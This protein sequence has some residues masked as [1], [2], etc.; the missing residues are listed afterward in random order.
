MALSGAGSEGR[1]FSGSHTERLAQ[2]TCPVSYTDK[3]LASQDTVCC[4]HPVTY[5]LCPVV[6]ATA[7]E[8]LG[9]QHRFRVKG[10]LPILQAWL[11][12]PPQGPVPQCPSCTGCVFL[13]ENSLRG[14]ARGGASV[15]GIQPR[16]GC[17]Q[18]HKTVHLPDTFI[19]DQ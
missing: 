2:A 14:A 11:C 1:F 3:H 10:W 19:G 6:W 15:L 17:L 12:P 5:T 9:A 16:G 4:P 18:G 8:T 7:W 13:Q